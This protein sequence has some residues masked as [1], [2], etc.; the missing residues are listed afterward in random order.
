MNKEKRDKERLLSMF[1]QI[2]TGGSL[3]I[4]IMA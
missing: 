2:F 1:A 3:N 4:L